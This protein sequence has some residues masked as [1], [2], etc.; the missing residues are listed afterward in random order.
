[1]SNIYNVCQRIRGNLD[2]FSEKSRFPAKSELWGIKG[3]QA[4][5]KSAQM[6]A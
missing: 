6:N 3:N 1:M 4:A 2:G 5:T